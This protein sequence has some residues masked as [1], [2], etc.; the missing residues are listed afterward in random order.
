MVDF[1]FYKNKE[2]CRANSTF[3]EDHSA[4]SAKFISS[5]FPCH[6]LPLMYCWSTAVH[7][8]V[9][10]ANLKYDVLHFQ[11]NPLECAMG[12]RNSIHICVYIHNANYLEG[13]LLCIGFW[14]GILLFF[15][16]LRLLAVNAL[17]MVWA[18]LLKAADD[19]LC[20]DHCGSKNW[21]KHHNWLPFCSTEL[22]IKFHY[23]VERR[24]SHL[25]VFASTDDTDF[26][27]LPGWKWFLLMSR[28]DRDQAR[29]VSL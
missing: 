28:S 8:N 12:N 20:S 29:S 5:R 27:L 17:A 21:A 9:D 16:V 10:I 15:S 26:V 24:H 19:E 13:V 7:I 25:Q 4:E 6:F 18:A 2:T 23:S 3:P 1:T 22:S 14:L 11:H